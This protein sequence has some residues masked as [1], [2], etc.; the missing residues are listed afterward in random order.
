ML[1]RSRDHGD[2]TVP[3]ISW[4]YAFLGQ[5]DHDPGDG[6]TEAQREA[7]AE[8]SGQSLVLCVRDRL[9]HCVFWYLVPRKGLDFQTYDNLAQLILADLEWL[10]Y[11][12]AIFR[13]DGE[14]ALKALLSDIKSRWN[15]EA[16]LEQ[17]AEGDPA[18]NG[19]AECGVGL[20]KGHVRTHKV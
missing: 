1:H 20:M 17:S 13:S 9:T 6:T 4:D 3:V 12:K 5:K 15:G 19:N 14:P 16:T 10:G 2:D 18:S 11:K 7:E 8:A